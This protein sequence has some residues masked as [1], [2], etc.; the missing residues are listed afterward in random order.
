MNEKV[1]LM[2]SIMDKL[3]EYKKKIREFQD[4]HDESFDDLNQI[5][6]THILVF[7]QEDNNRLVMR[8]F[9]C[10]R[11]INNG[12]MHVLNCLDLL[13]FNP[14]LSDKSR[15]MC[16]N[17]YESSKLLRDCIGG[18]LFP[19][20][21]VNWMANQVCAIEQ[22][23]TFTLVEKSMWLLS[24]DKKHWSTEVFKDKISKGEDFRFNTL[25]IYFSFNYKEFSKNW[26]Q[27]KNSLPFLVVK[28]HHRS[29][30]TWCNSVVSNSSIV[31]MAH[32]ER[33]DSGWYNSNFESSLREAP[34]FK[35]EKFE[36][37][38]VTYIDHMS[39]AAYLDLLQDSTNGDS[40]LPF[41]ENPINDDITKIL[42]IACVN[43]GEQ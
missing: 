32:S 36:L 42:C 8:V 1:R 10:K 13:S 14:A 19:Y 39:N 38:L 21:L 16:S 25:Y 30:L 41:F 3:K 29:F 18:S 24:A 22:L 15:Y 37:S 2:M 34:E 40:M 27:N 20:E 6:G 28:D 23:H 12:N 5:N 17:I 35:R 9:S 7:N 43:A 33:L 26:H 31:S 11:E 4:S